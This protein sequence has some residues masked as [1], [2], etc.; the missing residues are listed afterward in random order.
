MVEDMIFM[1]TRSKLRQ[2]YLSNSLPRLEEYH[3]D[4]ISTTNILN[5]LFDDDQDRIAQFRLLS[6]SLNDR[7]QEILDSHYCRV[8]VIH[9]GC[10]NDLE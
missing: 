9:K 10:L 4:V 8:Q 3:R 2:I 1:L 6:L 7:I 5:C